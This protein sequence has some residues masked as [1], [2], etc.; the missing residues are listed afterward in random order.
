MRTHEFNTEHSRSRQHTVADETS[1]KVSPAMLALA[2]DREYQ[3][4]RSAN[5]APVFALGTL[6]DSGVVLGYN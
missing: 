2:G 1:R 6:H 4:S 3:Q 5:A